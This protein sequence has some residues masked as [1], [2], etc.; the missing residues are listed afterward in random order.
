MSQIL[1]RKP[2][3]RQP[4]V[5]VNVRKSQEESGSVRNLEFSGSVRMS[6]KVSRRGN[7]QFNEASGRVR[8]GSRSVKK[9]QELSGMLLPNAAWTFLT[10][11][12]G[13]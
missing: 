9:H 6:Q 1:I 13:S 7:K 8:K 11:S 4:D 2:Q 3:L 12:D 10:L 5:S